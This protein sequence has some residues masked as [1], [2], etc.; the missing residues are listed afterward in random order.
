[1]TGKFFVMLYEFE[2]RSVLVQAAG[3]VV[4]IHYALKQVAVNSKE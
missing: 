3:I 1:M 2:S 4:Q